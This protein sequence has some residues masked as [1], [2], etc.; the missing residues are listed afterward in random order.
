MN[1]LSV[2]GLYH[3]NSSRQMDYFISFM[4]TVKG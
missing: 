2:A 3:V 4:D 1:V